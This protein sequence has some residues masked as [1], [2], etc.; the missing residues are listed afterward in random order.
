MTKRQMK[1]LC[2]QRVDAST[3]E[4]DAAHYCHD[5]RTAWKAYGW[6]RL[7]QAMMR[8]IEPEEDR[9]PSMH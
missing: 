2:C 7:A 3:I 9:K 6:R 8:G 1:C 4:P 5:C